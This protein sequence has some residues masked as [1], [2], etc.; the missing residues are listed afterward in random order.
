MQSK[1]IRRI[2]VIG[3]VH[4]EHARLAAV[5]ERFSALPLDRIVCTGDLPDGPGSGADVDACC[6]LLKAASVLTVCGNHDRWLLDS[7]HRDL[8]L[9]TSTDDV[10]QGTLAFLRSLPQT[11]ELAVPEGTALLCHGLGTD[12]MAEVLPFDHG[13]ALE[14]NLP[15]QTL[16][17]KGRYVCVI[18][19][20]SH[21]AMVRT[22][23]GVTIVNAGT[24]LSDHGPCCTV[25]DFVASTARFFDVSPDGEVIEG[26]AEAL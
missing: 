2:G 6:A 7:E 5:L 24:L 3:D 17:A 8:P 9:A 1:V 13:L 15:L 26:E 14:D 23:S 16:L 18:N 21:R 10:V 19:G 4:T 25:L 12:D 20:H 22:F 11:A